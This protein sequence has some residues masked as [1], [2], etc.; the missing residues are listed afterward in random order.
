MMVWNH[1]QE[2]NS[3]TEALKNLSTYNITPNRD[4]LSSYVEENNIG[5]IN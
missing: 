2:I 4:V 3:N 5:T 1:Y